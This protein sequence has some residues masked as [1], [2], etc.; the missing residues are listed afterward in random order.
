MHAANFNLFTRGVEN[1][2]GENRVSA[3]KQQG[4]KTNP[5]FTFAEITSLWALSGWLFYNGL[6]NRSGGGVAL[7]LGALLCFMIGFGLILHFAETY[8]NKQL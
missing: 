8:G 4:E 5:V 2:Y 6:P 1:E 3:D 7:T